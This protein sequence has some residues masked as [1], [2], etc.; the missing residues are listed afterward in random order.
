[1]FHKLQYISQGQSAEQQF[2]NI[3]EALVAGCKW[4]QLRFKNAEKEELKKLAK[5]IKGLCASHGAM[6]IVNDDP[7]IAQY[8]NADGVHLGLD[9][10][11][12]AEARKI[13]GNEK[14]IGGTANTFENVVQ[15]YNEGCSYV[16]VGPFR[17]TTTKEKLS[18]VLGAEG[19]TAIMQKMKTENI[20]IPVYAIGGITANDISNIM[21]TG[22]YGVAASGVLSNHPDK[23]Q[24]V[25]QLNAQLYA[26]A[27]YS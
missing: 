19:Y 8:A 3:H 1:M 11:S 16:G 12:V 18:P 13:L 15:R 9:D 23:K 21:N 2:A 26:E 6:F 5:K 10:L 25:Q 17:F 4:I 14:I 27:N 7:F 24:I 20:S 22:V